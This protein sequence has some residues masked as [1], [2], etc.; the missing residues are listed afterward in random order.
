MPHFAFP[1]ALFLAATAQAAV[2][3]Q[4]IPSTMPADYRKALD[5]ASSNWNRE[6][7]KY[8][9]FVEMVQTT[10]AHGQASLRSRVRDFESVFTAAKTPRRGARIPKA[11][12]DMKKA[13][14]GTFFT[15]LENSDQFP[16]SFRQGCLQFDLPTTVPGL[17]VNV[18]FSF[19]WTWGN[20]CKAGTPCF[21]KVEGDLGVGVSGEV[22]PLKGTAYVNG[23]LEM[24][25][26]DAIPC[27]DPDKT[28]ADAK[29]NS[30][31]EMATLEEEEEEAMAT[32]SEA[33]G[34]CGHTY[35]VK[36]F[37]R[38]Y[39]SNYFF[40]DERA[41]Q[42]LFQQLLTDHEK[43]DAEKGVVA[44]QA[45]VGQLMKE[46][47]G[48]AV[49]KGNIPFFPEE[50]PLYRMGR[51][52]NTKMED[53]LVPLLKVEGG[54]GIWKKATMMPVLHNRKQLKKAI[55]SGVLP[56]SPD[57]PEAAWEPFLNTAK[58]GDGL[59]VQADLT[60]A[61]TASQE[62]DVGTMREL[63][64]WGVRHVSSTVMLQSFFQRLGSSAAERLDYRRG[65]A[66]SVPSLDACSSLEVSLYDKFPVDRSVPFASPARTTGGTYG[67]VLGGGNGYHFRATPRML[68]SLGKSISNIPETGPGFHWPSSRGG[69]KQ[70]RRKE[71]KL[72]KDLCMCKQADCSDQPQ[73][74]LCEGKSNPAKTN[75]KVCKQP[76]GERLVG[77]TQGL[78]ECGWDAGLAFPRAYAVPLWTANVFP[79]LLAKVKE[80]GAKMA[81]CSAGIDPTPYAAPPRIGKKKDGE[82]CK[83]DSECAGG[84]CHESSIFSSAKCT[85]LGD[86]AHG[87]KAGT[88]ADGGTCY[89]YWQCK[90][91][92]CRDHQCVKTVVRQG[93][94]T[95]KATLEELWAIFKDD[96]LIDKMKADFRAAFGVMTKKDADKVC[97]GYSPADVDVSGAEP[98]AAPARGQ[99][100]SAEAMKIIVGGNGEAPTGLAFAFLN[101]YA[102]KIEDWAK[103][104][105]ASFDKAVANLDA[106]DAYT[107]DW[108]AELQIGTTFGIGGSSVGFC[109]PDT[110]SFQTLTP[111]LSYSSSF[112]PKVKAAAQGTRATGVSVLVHP[113]TQVGLGLTVVR[114]HATHEWNPEFEVR[115]YLAKSS[116]G[117]GGEAGEPL[118]FDFTSDS[119]LGLVGEQ[120]ISAILG[121]M[122]EM[123]FAADGD[124]KT[125]K[126]KLTDVV[127]SIRRNPEVWLAGAYLGILGGAVSQLAAM[128][129][130]K[131]AGVA[132]TRY[133]MLVI[134]VARGVVGGKTRPV[135]TAEIATLGTVE[136][137]IGIGGAAAVK[138]MIG[139]GKSADFGA[140]IN[141]VRKIEIKD[142]KQAAVDFMQEDKC[143]A[144]AAKVKNN[145][146]T[147]KAGL[148]K[149]KILEH[150]ACDDPDNRSD[151]CKMCCEL[152][153][154]VRPSLAVEAR[155]NPAQCSTGSPTP[156]RGKK[157]WYCSGSG[158]AKEYYD[159]EDTGVKDACTAASLED[160]G[161]GISEELCKATRA[162]LKTFLRA[163]TNS[164]FF[165]KMFG[166]NQGS[167]RKGFLREAA[168]LKLYDVAN[169]RC[170]GGES[171]N[172]D[173]DCYNEQLCLAGGVACFPGEE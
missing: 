42:A 11:T 131:V 97:A 162:E 55:K 17:S 166:E 106:A 127:N 18:G 46:I 169:A 102:V 137:T 70:L 89:R 111:V 134:K 67:A 4:H 10:G 133:V 100:T 103:A 88:V 132:A 32:S 168:R 155:I 21:M 74:L 159:H 139:F 116:F 61:L 65:D 57:F 69:R 44:E 92:E 115:L 5:K 34:K 96:V 118:E 147:G 86:A 63:F 29:K 164:G 75:R 26:S 54:Q 99:C 172:N 104:S 143:A 93:T 31:A 110:N 101:D 154:R 160:D 51:V 84:F 82:T 130:G 56:T 43:L 33:K 126:A 148:V 108:T 77:E 64:M 60:T 123:W 161:H 107:I 35:M 158:D 13:G 24:S 66:T 15:P 145:Q 50:Q 135:F 129:L 41:T 83:G 27:T 45:Y 167:T 23:H 87:G 28:E 157:K 48:N 39:I 146:D 141:K 144:I 113:I 112:G 128:A 7:T 1:C 121:T 114:D 6:T 8:E 14:G 120:T 9:E 117:N 2:Y 37:L 16:L 36:R 150:E 95:C 152:M 165:G 151:M 59:H 53:Y 73:C 71:C 76:P 38:H 105:K 49:E 20:K 94:N 47:Q 72:D 19:I 98:K 80:L 22:G 125:A 122:T 124:F 156:K 68:C 3:R 81:A 136:L 163:N 149:Q 170:G 173:P 30:D 140:L 40:A 138:P 90:S 78:V 62:R 52:I 85:P 91:T 153:G 142:E 119:V 58:M 12:A 79:S 171:S 25:A 109:T